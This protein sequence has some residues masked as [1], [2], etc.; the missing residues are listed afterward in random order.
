MRLHAVVD[1]SADAP[2]L[3]LLGS[4]GSTLEMWTP[5]LAPLAEQF[6]V[7]RID[8]R[9]HGGSPAADA[10]A[11]CALA[12]LA[13]DVLTT[14]DDLGLDRV[15]FAG[16]SLGGMVGM[17][18]ASRHPGRIDRLALLCTSP[19]LGAPYAERAAVVRA[20]G[21]AAVAD[22][23]VAR[24]ITPGLLDRDPHLRAALRTMITGIDAESYAQC[25]TAIAGMDLRPELA[26]IAAPTLAIAGAADVATPPEHLEAIASGIESARVAVIDAAAH[27]PTYE[28]PGRVAALM[29]RHLR[30]GATLA[31]GYATRRAVLGDEH[32]D[33]SV[34]STN[35][36]TAPFQEFLTRY[37]W[38]DVWTR[39]ELSRRDRSVVTLAVLVALGAEHELAMHVRAARRNG[40]TDSEIVE[41]V[42]HCALYAGLPR[43]NRAMSIVRAALDERQS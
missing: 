35:P 6:R 5:V 33:A 25:C 31:A 38:G 15:H 16:L 1:G 34:A 36:L 3:V 8:H 14:L 32:V 10:R 22:Q 20:H 40:L 11:D 37:A 9:G 28:R 4:L 19:H 42:M 21:M 26:R 17:W 39:A 41:V 2:T 13:D 12:D 29:L 43:A 24:W 30:A 7:V 27:V 18:L 23:V